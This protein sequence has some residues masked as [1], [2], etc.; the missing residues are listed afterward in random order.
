MSS[1]KYSCMRA[2]TRVHTASGKDPH[3]QTHPKRQHSLLSFPSL[4]S[5]GELTRGED[6]VSGARGCL[7]GVPL[8]SEPRLKGFNGVELRPG[9]MVKTRPT[10]SHSYKTLWYLASKC[11][12][13]GEIVS[14]P[15]L[16]VKTT[17]DYQ[18]VF[19]R[20][21]RLFPQGIYRHRHKPVLPQKSSCKSSLRFHQGNK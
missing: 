9:H 10:S 7:W 11:H 14:F 16:T 18:A 12:M 19:Q 5:G 20:K 4:P 8:G 15:S 17:K 2:H 6:S 1:D 3:S 13:N 21:N